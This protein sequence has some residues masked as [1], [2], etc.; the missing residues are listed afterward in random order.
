MKK[1]PPLF[2]YSVLRLLAFVIPLAI[3][4]LFF[5]I[6]REYWWLTAIF[7]ALIGASI[8]F[9]FLRGPLTDASGAIHERRTARAEGR[10]YGTEAED[11]AAE[12]A[13]TED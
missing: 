6:L 3:M 7:A 11:A 9:L 5:P 12:D 2:V 4:W 8:S 10:A 13:A 1:P